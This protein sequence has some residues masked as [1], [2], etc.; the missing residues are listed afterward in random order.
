MQGRPPVD[1]HSTLFWVPIISRYP[2]EF[3][4]WPHSSETISHAHAYNKRR[5]MTHTLHPRNLRVENMAPK[6]DNRIFRRT[7]E[8]TLS[9]LF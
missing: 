9:I 5:Y 3:Y 8:C 6:A 4:T 1:R 2:D 7:S